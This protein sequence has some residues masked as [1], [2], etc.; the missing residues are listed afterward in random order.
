ML[1]RRDAG[2]AAC[3]DSVVKSM[4]DYTLDKGVRKAKVKLLGVWE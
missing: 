4:T 2:R 1:E 3:Y